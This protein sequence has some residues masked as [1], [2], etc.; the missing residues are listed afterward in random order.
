MVSS[1]NFPLWSLTKEQQ[2]NDNPSFFLH[3]LR[4]IRDA[5]YEIYTLDQDSGIKSI[6]KIAIATKSAKHP[7]TF[8]NH[9]V[10]DEYEKIVDRCVS[11]HHISILED[12]I[13]LDASNADHLDRWDSKGCPD[14]VQRFLQR[15]L[16]VTKILLVWDHVL[17]E[18]DHISF[19][20]LVEGLKKSAKTM[21][22]LQEVKVEFVR[23]REWRVQEYRTE[24]TSKGKEWKMMALP[25][26]VLCC[27]MTPLVD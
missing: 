4:E 18:N 19:G 21:R 10:H 15:F 1:I 9:Q 12:C 23:R 22:S 27:M 25:S 3:I 16:A 7:L 8:V 26:P 17:R 20:E 2:S 13:A 6:G 11:H 5:T 14:T 24:W